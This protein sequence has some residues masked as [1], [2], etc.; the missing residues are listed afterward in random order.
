[1]SDLG[2]L[3]TAELGRQM[4]WLLVAFFLAGGAVALAIYKLV[5]WVL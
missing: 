4:F 5:E 3:I 2:E 1:M